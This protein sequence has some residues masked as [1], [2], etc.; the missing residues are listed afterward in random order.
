MTIKLAKHVPNAVK[1]PTI[2]IIGR[3]SANY[4]SL[5]HLEDGTVA[6]P[7]YGFGNRVYFKRNG[8]WMVEI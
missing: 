3:R 5:Y 6:A 2:G 4:Y 8:K 1:S 7:A